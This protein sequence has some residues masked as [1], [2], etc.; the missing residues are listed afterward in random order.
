MI[1]GRCGGRLWPS[2]EPDEQSYELVREM[3][4]KRFR[5]NGETTCA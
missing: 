4:G 1:C 2:P 3:E 5:Y